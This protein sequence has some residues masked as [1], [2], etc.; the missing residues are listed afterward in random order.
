VGVVYRHLPTTQDAAIGI[1]ADG[2]TTFAFPGATPARDLWEV[3]ARV[4]SKLRPDL[5]MVANLFAGSGEP[6]GNDRRL[7]HR[8]GA[9]LRAAKGSVKLAAA[10]KVNDWGP[11]DY[12]RDFNFTYPLQFTGDLSH[13]LGTPQWLDR[14]QTQ[15]RLGVRATWRSLDGNSP[16]YAPDP[17]SSAT[18]SPRGSE[19]EI[20]TYLIVAI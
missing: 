9:D 16:R 15:T 2:R 13:T 7:I 5:R 10:V 6:N 4:V 20:R 12:H 11:Y 18:D 14:Q 19:W 3:H 1:L 17:A 8:Y